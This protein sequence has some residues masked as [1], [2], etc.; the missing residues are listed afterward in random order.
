MSADDPVSKRL[1]R[2]WAQQ[3]K[4]DPV[5]NLLAVLSRA[6][7]VAI[8]LIVDGRVVRGVVAPDSAFVEA[9]TAAVRRPLEAFAGEWDAD[10]RA[11]YAE[12]FQRQAEGKADRHKKDRE[13]ADQY[14]EQ[15]TQPSIDNIKGSDVGPFYRELLGSSTVVLSQVRLDSAHAPVS[16][17]TMSVRRD[18]ISAWWFLDDEDGSEINYG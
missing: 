2:S 12:S 9:A 4:S 11:V 6:L 5:F 10:L 14:M 1:D 13:M 15:A 8:G 16:I 17:A 3:A 7:P 18:A